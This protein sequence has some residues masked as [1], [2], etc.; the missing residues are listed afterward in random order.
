MEIGSICNK[1]CLQSFLLFHSFSRQN[2]CSLMAYQHLPPITYNVLNQ[3]KTLSAAIFCYF[4]LGQMQSPLQ[5]VALLI[6]L[7]SAL[8]MESIVPLPF[9]LEKKKGG[10]GTAK[11]ND[12]SK[13]TATNTTTTAQEEEEDNKS[14]VGTDYLLLGLV[15]IFAAS[16]ISG[17]AGA[18]VQKSLKQRNSLLFSVELAALSIVILLVR[19]AV[20]AILSSSSTTATTTTTTTKVHWTT[21]WT[22]QTWIPV[23]TN[24]S[25][26]ILVGLVT[27]H[28]G[29]VRKGFALI[30]GMF[31]SG[32]L[33][34]MMF[35]ANDANDANANN[36][37][38]DNDEQKQRVSLHQWV[39]GALAAISLWMHSKYPH[40]YHR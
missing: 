37:N 31:L 33:Q 19:L 18:W 22:W 25:G 34:N 14:N 24:A 28:A 5:M 2:Y 10:G 32:I 23:W 13:D 12:D 17:L 4:L 20:N 8:V 36:N 35:L 15:P 38:D 6:L 27:K 30:L 1:D 26:G 16:S 40:Y 3:T 9:G 39:G 21:G 29:A 7:L 11:I